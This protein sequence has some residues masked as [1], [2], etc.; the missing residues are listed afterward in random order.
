MSHRCCA[1]SIHHHCCCAILSLNLS[2]IRVNHCEAEVDIWAHCVEP[3]DC[4]AAH[5]V[6]RAM[7]C[8]AVLWA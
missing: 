1:V 8:P 3:A 2:M 6:A 5:S 7:N 4:N